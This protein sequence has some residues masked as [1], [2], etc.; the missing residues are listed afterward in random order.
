[1]GLSRLVQKLLAVCTL[2]IYVTMRTTHKHQI[3]SLPRPA[4]LINYEYEQVITHILKS[5]YLFTKA[6][7]SLINILHP[8]GRGF[9]TSYSNIRAIFCF[10]TYKY[11][12]AN[13]KHRRTRV[14][15]EANSTS[16]A[17]FHSFDDPIATHIRRLKNVSYLVAYFILFYRH[18]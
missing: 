2:L 7:L 8:P 4:Y 15:T 16:Y 13:T 9:D 10:T 12:I 5:K 11:L 3:Y 18:F 1:M 6:T 14:R 17:L